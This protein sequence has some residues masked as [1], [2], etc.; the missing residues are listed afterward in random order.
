[1]WRSSATTGTRLLTINYEGAATGVENARLLNMDE[2]YQGQTSKYCIFIVRI[3]SELGTQSEDLIKVFTEVRLAPYV[4]TYAPMYSAC[5]GTYSYVRT[6][7]V[8]R[9]RTEQRQMK[10]TQIKNDE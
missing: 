1:M 10:E 9:L 8:E 3:R 2:R 4:Y 7:P 6:C 5:Q